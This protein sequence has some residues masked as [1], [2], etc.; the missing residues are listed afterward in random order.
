MSKTVYDVLKYIKEDIQKI[1]TK[2]G[3][4]ISYVGKKGAFHIAKESINNAIDECINPKSNGDKILIVYDIA[5]GELIITD[6]GRGILENEEVT[7][8]I[9]CTTLN[10]GSKFTREQGG[11]TAGENGVGLT[12]TNAMSQ[13]FSITTIVEGRKHVVK[14]EDGKK[15]LDEVE[16]V[17]KDQHGTEVRFIPSKKYLGKTAEIPYKDLI[18]WVKMISYLLEKDMKIKFEVYNGFELVEK[19]KFK[20]LGLKALLEEECKNPSSSLTSL[21]DSIN[22]DEEGFDM[23]FKRKI[24]KRSLRLDFAFCYSDD[25]TPYIDSYCNY[26]NTIDGGIHLEAVKEG[27]TRYLVA[28]TKKSLSEREKEKMDILWVDVTT[29]LNFVVNLS[30]DM[31][32]QFASQTKEKLA[33]DLLTEPIKQLTMNLLSAHFEE[34]KEKLNQLIKIVKL[35]A[36]ARIE[37]NK[38][39]Q[40]VM[41]ERTNTFAEHQMKNF[42]PANNRGKNQYREIYIVE[43]KSTLGS[44][45]GGRN[46][47]TQAF[48]AMR[49]VTANALKRSEIREIIANNEWKE[50]IKVLGCDIGPSFDITKLRY[51]KI[52]ILTDADIDGDGI[53]S[54]IATFFMVF[55]PQIV[56]AGLL[57]KAVTPLYEVNSKVKR[58]VSTKKEFIELFQD[59]IIKNYKIAA[60]FIDE[61][62]MNKDEFTEFI[63]DTKS[64]L[65]EII[66]ISKHYGLKNS[67]I[68][69]ERVAA[70]FITMASPE[71]YI[72]DKNNTRLMFLHYIQKYY[73]E[74]TLSENGVL[75][76]IVDGHYRSLPIN[77]RFFRKV[78]EVWDVI[79]KY[80]DILT[81][82]DKK[83]KVVSEKT[84]GEFLQ[85]TNKYVPTILHRFKGLGESDPE[86]LEQTTLANDRLLIQLSSDDIERDLKTFRILHGESKEDKIARKE[87]MKGFKI[88]K[89]E[90]DN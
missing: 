43:G 11:R 89:D 71:D 44:L 85:D 51:N 16:N 5:S 42:I 66:S 84:I 76:G 65:Q 77:K 26:V 39:K 53:T 4:Y 8:D 81:V 74:V 47:D 9:L 40:S 49:G 38:V 67:H 56:E 18:K 25:E 28:A 29:G 64:Y 24:F 7:L 14:Y 46:Q 78:R 10:S 37:S 86:E 68:L 55:Y 48:F 1:Q 34:K 61:N 33:N 20:P 36:K 21:T 54:L 75:R 22:L 6:N 19:H 30:T 59:N 63:Y 80:G 87:I 27:I 72:E 57:Y 41:K 17:S 2:P 90:L 3:M 23:Q 58:F 12:A 82:E 62:Y 45:A 83:I 15:I 31:Q 50:L 70:F 32:V 88:S 69:I 35:N 73:P 60:P 79:E 52:I 13:K